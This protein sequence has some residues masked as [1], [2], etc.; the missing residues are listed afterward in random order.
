[1]VKNKVKKKRKI[2]ELWL[3]LIV[4][5]FIVFISIATQKNDLEKEAE[6]ILN[7]LTDDKEHSFA[8]N[9]IIEEEK[10]EKISDMDYSELKNNLNIKNEF[11]VYFE[12]EEGNLF[13][14]KDGL[15]SI[16][17]NT[18]KINGVSCGG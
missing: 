18:I 9:N 15:K 3:V 7:E 8:P 14:I 6:T 13:E 11:C 4:M 1:M 5:I 17:S 12:D 10:L 2:D 16:G